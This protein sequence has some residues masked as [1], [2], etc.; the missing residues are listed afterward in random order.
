MNK[1]NPLK[2]PNIHIY[3]CPF[4]D[5]TFPINRF[6]KALL[7]E[8]Q[9][10]NSALAGLSK[11]TSGIAF[12]FTTDSEFL[13]IEAEL[14]SVS[15]MNHM[16]MTAESGFDLYVLEEGKLR[17]VDVSRPDRL[18]TNHSHKFV[19]NPNAKSG[20]YMLYAP[21]YNGIED[22]HFIISESTTF[23]QKPRTFHKRM[24]VYG[25]SITQGACASRPGLSYT[26]KLSRL[27]SLE[28][29]NYGFSG[30]GLG[31]QSV[32]KAMSLIQ[33]LDMIVIDYE[34]NAGAVD[35]L[36]PTFEYMIKTLRTAHPN[37]PIIVL[38]R[39]PTQ[40]E[41]INQ[42]LKSKRL[43]HQRFMKNV[44]KEI[45]RTHYIPGN[46]LL[47]LKYEDTTVDGIHFND[48]GFECFTQSLYN[49]LKKIQDTM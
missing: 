47:P 38:G 6:P 22:L 2:D 8:I 14:T 48:Y 46:L 4:C 33:D 34:A 10:E 7:Q 20:T 13:I 45:D 24:L 41:I 15:L 16:P 31:E 3:G 19:L 29:I 11:H 25:T 1:I 40:Y 21:L 39:V 28:V 43:K 23:I 35:R 18:S 12:E 49:K 42:S 37:T 17:F 9:T 27:M 32:I 36:I 30:N 44:L 26:A 5:E